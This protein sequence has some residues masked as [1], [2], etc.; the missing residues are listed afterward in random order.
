MSP[1]RPRHDGVHVVVPVR[2]FVGAKARLAPRLAPDARTALARSMAER[3]VK[4]AAPMPVTVVTSAGEVVAWARAAGLDLCDD[5][6]TLDAA[7]AAG[8][9][10]AR[11]AGAQRVVVAHADLPLAESFDPVLAAPAG[12]VVLVPDRRH[13]GTPVIVVPDGCA[14]CFSYGPGSF[15]RH[16]ESA[17]RAGW[18]VAVVDDPRLATDVDL[19]DDLQFVAGVASTP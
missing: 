1:A 13:D 8:L 7:A 3:V 15:A 11:A 10:R 9:A 17:V 19:P 6:G 2:S 14:F 16:L 4:A 5:P 12:Q 18:P